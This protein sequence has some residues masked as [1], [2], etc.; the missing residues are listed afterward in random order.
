MFEI[1]KES[2][3]QVSKSLD[4]I[5]SQ[6]NNL[7]EILIDGRTFK[8]EKY[9]CCDLKMLAILYGINGANSNQPCIWCYYNIKEDIQDNHGMFIHNKM[10]ISRTL[11]EATRIANLGLKDGLNGYVSRPI[12]NIDFKFCMFDSLHLFLRITDKLFT[13][14]FDYIESCDLGEE[15]LEKRPMMKLF[16]NFL[17]I[18][19]KLSNVYYLKQKNNSGEKIKIRSLNSN[20]LDKIFKTIAEVTN[21][22]ENGLVLTGLVYILKP[23]QVKLVELEVINKLWLSFY[24]FYEIIKNRKIPDSIDTLTSSLKYFFHILKVH[25]FESCLNLTPYLHTLIHHL[26]VF[27]EIHGDLDIFNLQG[28]EKLNHVLKAAYFKNTNKKSQIYLKQL[29]QIRN[30]NELNNFNYEFH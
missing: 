29:L 5:I 4:G 10:Q 30:R 22:D 2:Y 20:E 15:K 11:D 9:L 14:L 26:P 7:N 18:D 3:D 21:T 28:L 24:K 6:L 25:R 17:T 12:I 1:T 8:I 19:C 23:S 16:L 13:I 27:L